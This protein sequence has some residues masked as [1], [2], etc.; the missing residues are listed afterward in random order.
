MESLRGLVFSQLDIPAWQILLYIGLNSFFMLSRRTRSCLVTTYLFA[1]YWTFYLFRAYWLSNAQGDFL[2]LAAYVLFAFAVMGLLLYAFFFDER[3]HFPGFSSYEIARLQRTLLK[4]IERMEKAVLEA[5]TRAV[6]E[7]RQFE[8]LKQKIE[9]RIGPLESQVRKIDEA[10]GQ[11]EFT[12]QGLEK[13]L[14]TQLHDLECQLGKKEELLQSR[15]KEIQGLRS[16]V[17][18]KSGKL[19]AQL[20]EGEERIQREVS[21]KETEE[22]LSATV[23]DLERQLAEKEALLLARNK[24]IKDLRLEAQQSTEALDSESRRLK[25]ELD[26]RDASF[27]EREEEL[28]AQLKERD[29]ELQDLKS[30]L[31]AKAP[32]SELQEKVATLQILLQAQEGSFARRAASYKEVVDSLTSRIEEL[33]KQLKDNGRHGEKPKK[34]GKGLRLR[35]GSEESTPDPSDSIEGELEKI[36]TGLREGEMP[37]RPGQG[38]LK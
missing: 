4:R 25:A 20:Q 34:R 5:E 31:E 37:L 8:G 33:E 2:I 22:T 17:E 23:R 18:E 27:K 11:R 10:L 29:Q 26:R 36:R 13:G 21:W 15:D 3:H 38:G 12:V 9:T 1:L 35:E 24:E 6:S 14:L 19:Q 16:E 32:A 7:I 28:T 30:E